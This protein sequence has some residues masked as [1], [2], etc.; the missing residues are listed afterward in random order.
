M[1]STRST[2]SVASVASVMTLA[3]VDEEV[4][5]GGEGGGEA[6]PVRVGAGQGFDCGH[7]GPAQRLVEGE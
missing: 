7:H 6:G 1:S 3:G 2:T 5:G 4:L